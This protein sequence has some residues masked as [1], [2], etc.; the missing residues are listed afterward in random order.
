MDTR[1]KMIK[2]GTQQNDTLKTPLLTQTHSSLFSLTHTTITMSII[3]Q[4][5]NITF[6]SLVKT[7]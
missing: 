3:I 2:K 5:D 6:P 7:T 4:R 1:K